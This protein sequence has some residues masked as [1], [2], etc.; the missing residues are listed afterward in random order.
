MRMTVYTRR[1]FLP[2]GDEATRVYAKHSGLL[3]LVAVAKASF[4]TRHSGLARNF[5]IQNGGG[6][7]FYQL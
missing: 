4:G 3:I 2:P 7:C 6:T 5:S 1:S